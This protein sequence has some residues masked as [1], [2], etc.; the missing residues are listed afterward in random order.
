MGAYEYWPPGVITVT[1]V[2][3]GLVN[4]TPGNPYKYNE[5]ATLEPVADSGWYFGGWSGPDAGE[6][7]DNGDGTWSITMDGNKAVT[8]TFTQEEYKIYLPIIVR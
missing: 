3:N 5:V 1:V 8:A 6:L 2:G 7:V 4:N